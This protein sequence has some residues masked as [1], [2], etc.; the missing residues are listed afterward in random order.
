MA[1]RPK[2]ELPAR[3]RQALTRELRQVRRAHE[4]ANRRRDRAI[5]KAVSKGMPVREVGEA[6][7]LSHVRVLQ[8]AKED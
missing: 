1:A 7:G 5:R 4:T 2:K 3:T 6:V 8:I